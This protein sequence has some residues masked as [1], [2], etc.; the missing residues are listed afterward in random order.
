MSIATIILHVVESFASTSTTTADKSVKPCSHGLDSVAEATRQVR[1][2]AV[3]R[4]VFRV[5]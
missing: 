4:L 3:P 5:D 1:G 2:S